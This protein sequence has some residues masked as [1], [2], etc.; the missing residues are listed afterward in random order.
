MYY[1]SKVMQGAKPRHPRAEQLALALVLSDPEGNLIKEALRLRFSTTNNAVEYEA[2]LVGLQLVCSLKAR[3]I[4]VRSDSQLVVSHMDGRF[5]A[6]IEK[7]EK[8]KDLVKDLS[9]K[10]WKIP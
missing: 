9:V 6:M 4:V 3:K 2:L 8:Y 10:T 7:M 5:E 1:V